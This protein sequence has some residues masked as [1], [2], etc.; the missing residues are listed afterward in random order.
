MGYTRSTDRL[1]AELSRLPGVGR[2]AAQTMVLDI[3]KLPQEEAVRLARLIL[4]VKKKTRACAACFN[5]TEEELCPICSDQARDRGLL[6][7]VE[8]PH[9]L[10]ALEKA[11]ASAA[12]TTSSAACSRRWRGS[13]RS[14]CASRELLE[15]IG[16]GSFREVLIATN[17]TL[18]GE[19]TALY[20]G[21]QLKGLGVAGH[22]AGA[23]RAGGRGAGVHRRADAGEGDREPARYIMSDWHE[24]TDGG[25]ADEGDYGDQVARAGRAGRGLRG[26]DPRRHRDGGRGLRPGL[27]RV[28]AG[29]RGGAGAGLQPHRQEEV[30]DLLRDRAPRGDRRHGPDAPRHGRRHRRR[31]AGDALPDQQPQVPRRHQ[32]GAPAAQAVPGD[33]RS[34]RRTSRSRR[35][36]RASRTRRRSGRWRRSPASSASTRCWRTSRASS[37]RSSPPRSSKRT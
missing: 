19:A 7:V 27:P 21:R 15:R 18:E 9:D 32:G 35:S 30:L 25:G 31:D 4:E 12:S 11:G 23:R 28:R 26:E 29:A 14:S 13:G 6:C 33:A 10:A 22:A 3:L 20:L 16:A 17:P 2:R 36:A 37:A 8:E 24:A 1:I 34:T 5:L